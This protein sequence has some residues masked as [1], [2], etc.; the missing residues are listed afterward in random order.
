MKTK[1]ILIKILA[2]IMSSIMIFFVSFC[3]FN[4]FYFFISIPVLLSLIFK[5]P[6]KCLSGIIGMSVA[7]YFISGA[8]L[9]MIL[10]LSFLIAYLVNMIIKRFNI[11]LTHQLAIMGVVMSLSMTYM[12]YVGPLQATYINIV[13]VPILVGI[14]SYFSIDLRMS[15]KSNDNFSLTKKQ[16]FYVT[17]VIGYIL[18]KMNIDNELFNMSFIGFIL[19]N[20]V[21][22]RVDPIMGSLSVVGTVI[23]TMY[24]INDVS[25]IFMWIPLVLA[26]RSVY[27]RSYIGALAYFS[28][29]LIF[30]YYLND[31]DY[32]FEVFLIGVLVSIIP[33]FIMNEFNEMVVEPKDYELKLYQNSYYSCIRR[34]RKVQRVMDVLEAQMKKNYKLKKGSK[35]IYIKNMEFLSNK[36]KEEE[37]IDYKENIIKDLTIR[38]CQVIGLKIFYDIM[39]HYDIKLET[40]GKVLETEEI[41]DIFQDRLDLKVM[42]KESSYN[43][44]TNSMQYRFVKAEEYALKY[45]IRQRSKLETCGDSYLTFDT[46][47]KKYFLI[48]DGMGH[49]KAANKHAAGAILLLKSFIELGMDPKDAITSCNSII[50]D[51]GVERFNTLDLLEY[52]LIQQKTFLY[53]NGSGTTYVKSNGEVR[54]YTSAN[55]PLGI[56]ENINVSKLEIEMKPGYIILTSDGIKSD[57]EKFL[58]SINNMKPQELINIIFE[59]EGEKIDDDQTIVVINVIKN[60]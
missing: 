8:N 20:Y 44:F 30:M 2:E 39:L 55:L 16:A 37:D 21:L 51:K 48:S 57:L 58:T 56:V 49:G 29:N 7:A 27:K 35:D 38:G 53:K 34:N 52:D 14:L 18:L 13:I 31:Y 15:L 4:G 23:L 24:P 25:I 1:D 26:F 10:L 5:K 9:I 40:K 59:N 43:F 45:H 42:L 46:K 6:I 60:K 17:F 19:L 11:S 33:N 50:F 22:M 12:M 47:N 3:D 36:L 41:I 28:L 54:K 32:L